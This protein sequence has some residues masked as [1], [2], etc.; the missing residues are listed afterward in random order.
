MAEQP[1]NSLGLISNRFGES[2]LYEVNRNTF[3]R[4]GAAAVFRRQFGEGLRQ[5]DTLYIIVG[6][7]S[8]LLPAWLL[9]QGVPDGS[10]YLFVELPEV[11]AA[12]DDRL[13]PYTEHARVA[14]VTPEH[15]EDLREDFQFQDYAYLGR[16][17]V[18]GSVGA[19]DAY[20]PGYRPLLRELQQAVDQ[21][22]WHIEF[23]LGSQAFVR[24]QVE[25]VAD[26]RVRAI[27]LR[28]RFAGR[29]AVL[30][31]GGPSLDELLPWVRAHR[32]RLTVIAVS[33]I[34]RRLLQIDLQ[35]DIVVSIDPHP[36]SFDVSK[37]MLRFDR[38]TLLLNSYHVSPLLLAQWHG[39]AV[40]FGPSYP[41]QSKANVENLPN[42]G[43]TVTNT[44][45]AMAVELGF[46]QVILGGVDLCYSREGH[47]HAEGSNER[48]AGPMLGSSDIRVQT[49]GGWW[50]DTRHSFA[51]AV[52]IM[53]NQAQKAG[54][55]GCRIINPAAGAAVIEHVDYCPPEQL[56]E[57]AASEPASDIIAACLP[58][59]DRADR[60]RHYRAAARELA[61]INGRLR[62]MRKLAL[63]ALDCNDGLFGRNGR[64][65]DF[66][67]KKRMDKIE[68]R[69]DRD[70]DDLAPLV[71]SFGSRHFLRLVRPDK[72]KE[73]SDE[74]IERWGRGYYESYQTSC[75]TLL[76]MVEDAQA[77]VAARQEELAGHPDFA[78]LFAQWDKDQTPGRALILR[79]DRPEL[80]ADA[81]QQA[82]L[83]AFARAFDAVL[84]ASDTQQAKWCAD[85][86]TLAPVRSR[87][88]LLLQHR[89]A[90]EL[91]RLAGELAQQP[92]DEARELHLL[93]SGY[94]AELQD[95][96]R[97]ALAAYHAIVDSAADALQPGSEVSNP[98]LED[99][100]RRMS[101][102][103]LDLGDMDNAVMVL[104]V[105]SSLAPVYAP[106]YAE[107]LRLTGNLQGALQVL[108][109][110]L[111]RAPQD[112]NALLRLGKL[113]EEMGATDS[114]RW[115]YD[116]VLEQ[117]PDNPAARQL[118]GE[119]GATADIP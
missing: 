39:P 114:A 65:A 74:E 95:E 42:Q 31:G 102:I 73:W 116:T 69:L 35:P 6:T 43:P 3:D 36:V 64:Q 27:G 7:D 98:R 12:L 47:T 97:Q 70:F 52:E 88:A 5:Q 91:Q 90:E 68:R 79:E 51:K 46:S 14:C 41:W 86:Y 16:I 17:R 87:L 81:G 110:Y 10:R 15:W 71:K 4:L 1:S 66:K 118:L 9:E 100:L 34:C 40:F 13:A 84:D 55:R 20:L 119:L 93:A 33:R 54:E 56:P 109:D 105:L 115:A 11:L 49:N 106:Q 26:N 94:L 38:R 23:Q 28:D 25:N 77:R 101:T 104:D 8:G 89:E 85:N 107:L 96:P 113:F 22:V 63:E 2:C 60:Q 30:L 72:D 21:F 80:T 18:K 108:T 103:T 111:K 59:D 50:A 92:G 29:T 32:D 57:P 112:I 19:L 117:D 99:A 45:L 67:Y 48:Q 37:E 82:R 24:R 78:C 83:D 58:E 62:S 76:E 44:A 75:D 61:H 53:G